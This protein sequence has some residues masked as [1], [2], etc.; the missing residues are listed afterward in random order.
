MNHKQI[1][2]VFYNQKYNHQ[3]TKVELLQYPFIISSSIN[4]KIVSVI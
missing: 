1:L 2:L 4:R 3:R